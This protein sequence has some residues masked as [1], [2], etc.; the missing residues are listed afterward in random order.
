MAGLLYDVLGTYFQIYWAPSK[1]V[2]YFYIVLSMLRCFGILGASLGV[3][4]KRFVNAFQSLALIRPLSF[5][6][7]Q[8][9]PTSSLLQLDRL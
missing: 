2:E 5:R 4:F 6:A 1:Y 8:S 7:S 3:W 9:W